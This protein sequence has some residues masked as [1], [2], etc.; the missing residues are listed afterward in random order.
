MAVT[1]PSGK[2]PARL[3]GSDK[4]SVRSWMVSVVAAKPIGYGYEPS[5]FKYFSRQFYDMG[6]EDYMAICSHVDSLLR[7]KTIYSNND[8]PF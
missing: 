5:A 2:C 3:E 6:K 4:E 1:I 8:F 7:G